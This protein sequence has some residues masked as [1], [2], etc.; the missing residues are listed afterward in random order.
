MQTG[1]VN[2][3]DAGIASVSSPPVSLPP[4]SLPPVSSQDQ[5][6]EVERA[7]ADAGSHGTDSCGYVT[8]ESTP[9]TSI[10]IRVILAALAVGGL[11]VRVLLARAPTTLSD[12]LVR[13]VVSGRAIW[14]HGLHTAGLPLVET[15]PWTEAVN[16]PWRQNPYNYPAVP[17]AFFTF[18]ATFGGGQMVA[19]LFFTLFDAISSL[20]ICRLTKRKWLGLSYWL[21]PVSMW[22]SSH[23]GQFEGMQAMLGFIA[24]ASISSPFICGVFIALAVQTK[25]TAAALLP[26]LIWR[27]HKN[28]TVRRFV[29]GGLVGITPM[30]AISFVYPILGNVLRYSSEIRW[31]PYYWNMF[32]NTRE[33]ATP[34]LGG[35]I[36][37]AVLSLIFVFAVFR[38]GIRGHQFVA[39]SAFAAYVVMMKFHIQFPGWYFLTFPLVLAPLAIPDANGATPLQLAM[40]RQPQDNRR[41]GD[42]AE[43]NQNASVKFGAARIFNVVW[44]LALAFETVALTAILVS[45]F[46]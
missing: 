31:N 34:G 35:R 39:C 37:P 7:A 18:L 24:L 26:Y 40:R 43:T 45:P 19:R 22:W 44:C 9:N 12:D 33:W 1:T 38:I 15:L 17:V 23:E 3:E 16:I 6:A 27:M 28:E 5:L 21:S 20:L 46:R 2:V 13:S 30:I 41:M 29:I 42:H 8:S 25:M 11:I 14:S 36:L 10:R 32:D 4:V